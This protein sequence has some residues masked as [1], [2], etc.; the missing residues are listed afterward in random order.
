[1]LSSELVRWSGQ[2]W[3]HVDVG[4]DAAEALYR[5]NGYAL[6][7]EDPVWFG[8]PRRKVLNKTFLKDTLAKKQ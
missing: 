3:L 7:R 1:M 5:A 2:L 4:N 8:L 6:F